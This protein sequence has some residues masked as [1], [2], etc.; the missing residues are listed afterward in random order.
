MQSDP[1]RV[2]RILGKAFLAA[3]IIQTAV[4]VVLG[5][6]LEPIVEGSMATL[7]V[8]ILLVVGIANVAMSRGMLM[9][10]MAKARGPV[11]TLASTGYAFADAPAVY[12]LVSAIMTG[13]GLVAIPFGVVALVSWYLTKS[14]LSTVSEQKPEEFPRL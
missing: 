3:T 7:L 9:P 13:E 10:S 2:A 11:S 8:G 4:G 1:A 14:F 5:S 12:G 6:I